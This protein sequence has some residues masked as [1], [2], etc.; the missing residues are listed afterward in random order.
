MSNVTK[1]RRCSTGHDR[2]CKLCNEKEGC[3]N[4]EML[5]AHCILILET[6]QFQII[7]TNKVAPSSVFFLSSHL[8]SM[9]HLLWFIQTQESGLGERFCYQLYTLPV[10][11]RMVLTGSRPDWPIMFFYFQL[12]RSYRLLFYAHKWD[13]PI[14]NSGNYKAPFTLKYILI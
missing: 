13:T 2:S 8:L 1:Q 9:T 6:N 7:V 4:A 12:V 3:K 5:H 10:V 14:V 11:F